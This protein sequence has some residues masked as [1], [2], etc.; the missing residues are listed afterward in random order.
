MHEWYLHSH[1]IFLVEKLIARDFQYIWFIF[2][3]W[4]MLIQKIKE[5]QEAV[6]MFRRMKHYD[7]GQCQMSITNKAEN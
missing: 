4:L 1:I 3:H 7:Q 2:S 5:S 6:F